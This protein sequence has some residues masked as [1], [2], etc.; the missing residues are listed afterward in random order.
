[1]PTS[2]GSGKRGQPFVVHDQR[3]NLVLR[4]LGEFQ[5]NLGCQRFPGFIKEPLALGFHLVRGL[6][7]ESVRALIAAHAQGKFLG[8]IG[9]PRVNVLDLNLAMDGLK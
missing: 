9:E 4:Q 6:A 1:M 7:P 3:L 5:R 8:L 2:L